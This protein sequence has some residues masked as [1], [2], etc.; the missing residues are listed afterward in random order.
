MYFVDNGIYSLHGIVSLT[1]SHSSEAN[2]CNPQEY[3]VFTDSAR[4]LNWIR[5]NSE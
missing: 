3:V 5:E 1:V 4:Y 2:F